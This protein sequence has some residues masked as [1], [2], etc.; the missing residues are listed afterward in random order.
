M[1]SGRVR[2]PAGIEETAL[3]KA[4]GLTGAFEGR[5]EQILC[6]SQTRLTGGQ[7]DCSSSVLPGFTRRSVRTSSN[8][9]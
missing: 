7:G 5:K 2:R 3:M 1:C 9:F 8:D 4:L 6:C